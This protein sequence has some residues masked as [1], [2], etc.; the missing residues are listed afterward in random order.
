[1]S[2]RSASGTKSVATD[3][4]NQLVSIAMNLIA[5]KGFEGLR[6]QEVA[7]EAGINNATLYYYFPTKE[8][9]IQGVVSRAT[10][11]L[12]LQRVH[13]KKPPAN[14]LDELRLELEGV[15]Q[16]LRVHPSLFIVLTELALRAQRD[17][18]VRKIGQDRDDFWRGHLSGII[19]RGI[20]QGLFRPDIDVYATV[21]A[22]MMQVKGIGYHAT[23]AK[24]RPGEVDKAMAVIIA[25]VEQWLTVATRR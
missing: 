1:M 3:R 6:F 21:T 16:L 20:S 7:E 24:R 5:T 10:G 19:E 23:M 9:L 25:Q 11:E 2:S 12:K 13:P 4:R 14:A 15:R 17:P 18:V 8:A 22:L